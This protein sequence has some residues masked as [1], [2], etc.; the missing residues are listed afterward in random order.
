MNDEG[1]IIKLE[2]ALLHSMSLSQTAV[3]NLFYVNG[4]DG[5][6][7]AATFEHKENNCSD[8][9]ARWSRESCR[10]SRLPPLQPTNNRDPFSTLYKNPHRSVAMNSGS[11]RFV[12]RVPCSASFDDP[13]SYIC[14]VFCLLSFRK[15]FF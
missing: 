10:A 13:F 15:R 12:G 4:T 3:E 6:P 7:T 8:C 14:V 9:R 2:T 1:K 11:S 5:I